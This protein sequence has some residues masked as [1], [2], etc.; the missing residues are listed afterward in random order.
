MCTT[1]LVQKQYEYK[2]H[3]VDII[4]ETDECGFLTT[5][6]WMKAPGEEL[7]TLYMTGLKDLTL[8]VVIDRVNKSIDEKEVAR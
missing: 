4:I 3:L 5:D 1:N 2:G 8:D 6:V 7:Q